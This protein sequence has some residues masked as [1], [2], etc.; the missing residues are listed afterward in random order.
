[1]GPRDIENGVCV[2]VRRDT[3]EKITVKLEKIE[4]KIGEL[5]EEIHT[6][7]YET[8][9]KRMEAKTT[10]AHNLEEFQANMN[11]EQGFIKAMWCGSAECEAKIKE[12]TAYNLKKILQNIDSLP[13]IK[14]TF[15]QIHEAIEETTII[16]A[17]VIEEKNKKKKSNRKKK[18][19]NRM[20][21]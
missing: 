21:D 18:S 10:V 20:E 11:K 7:M 16:D 13:Q 9:K 1:M 5:L 17:D 3:A 8:C 4:E 14:N 2:L 6:N 15:N 19:K 12:L